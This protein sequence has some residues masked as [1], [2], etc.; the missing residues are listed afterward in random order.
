MEPIVECTAL[1]KEEY[2]CSVVQKLTMRKREM[3]S[4]EKEED[5]FRRGFIGY[6]SGEFKN[7]VHARGVR[8]AMTPLQARGVLLIHAQT[9]LYPGMV[10][11][12]SAKSQDLYLNPYVKKQLSNV[13]AAGRMRRSYWLRR[14]S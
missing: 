4:Y 9:K 5:R 13:P 1:V 8:Y 6:M 11:G 10:I 2:A 14:G 3:V 7:D 12:E